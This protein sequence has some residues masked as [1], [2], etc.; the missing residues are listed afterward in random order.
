[1]DDELY[2][3][4]AGAVQ[5]GAC[6]NVAWQTYTQN[7]GILFGTT[8]V[9]MIISGAVPLILIGPIMCGMFI[10]FDKALHEERP[11]FNDLFRGFDFFGPSLIASLI[12]F[13]LLLAIMIPAMVLIVVVIGG[14]AAAFGEEG[15]MVGMLLGMLLYVVLLI[16]SAALWIGFAFVFQLIVDRDL[17]PME[18]V[19]LSFRAAFANLGGLIGIYFLCVLISLLGM[20]LCF[21]GV[22]LVMPIFF[23]AYHVAYRQVFGEPIPL[24]PPVPAEA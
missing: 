4:N 13:G 12:M 21:V 5:A 11:E 10:V 16:A 24:P 17:E 9:G 1:M 22:Y 18:A 8:L 20:L 3:F 23:G 7:F 14:S 15:G 19:K 2:Q 6:V